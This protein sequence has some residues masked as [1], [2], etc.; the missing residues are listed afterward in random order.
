[1][2]ITVTVKMEASTQAEL[3]D[4]FGA[5][6]KVCKDHFEMLKSEG[7]FGDQAEV[8][9]RYLVIGGKWREARPQAPVVPIAEPE[10]AV[11]EHGTP[12]V[13]ENAGE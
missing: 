1:M 12:D 9:M 7:V 6:V 11:Q 3:I 4:T 13:G 2:H 5:Q 8:D 10:A